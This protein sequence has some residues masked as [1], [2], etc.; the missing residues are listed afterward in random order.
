MNVPKNVNMFRKKFLE[1]YHFILKG[2]VTRYTYR[3]SKTV[4][5]AYSLSN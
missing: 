5:Y 4:N 2:R 3:P 1:H